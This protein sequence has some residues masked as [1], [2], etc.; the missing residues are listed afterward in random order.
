MVVESL[1]HLGV[2]EVVAALEMEV[3]TS[4]GKPRCPQ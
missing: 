1:V 2:V 3:I 4:K